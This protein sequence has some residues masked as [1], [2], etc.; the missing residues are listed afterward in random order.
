[1]HGYNSAMT[2]F[3]LPAMRLRLPCRALRAEDAAP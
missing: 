3:I 2:C 1:M